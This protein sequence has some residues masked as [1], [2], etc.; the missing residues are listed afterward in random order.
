MHVA[1][2]SVT[3][4]RRSPFSR[5]LLLPSPLC[6]TYFPWH[7]FFE[8]GKRDATNPYVVLG[9]GRQAMWCYIR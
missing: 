1:S 6:L 2:Q 4:S 3:V 8:G 9:A 5:S 7:K